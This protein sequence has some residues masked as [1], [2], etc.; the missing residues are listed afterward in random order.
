M[1]Y[2][3]IAVYGKDKKLQ[4]LVEVKSRHGRSINWA[5]QMRRNMYAHGLLPETRFFY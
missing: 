4:L 2:A 1:N 3:D 5:A